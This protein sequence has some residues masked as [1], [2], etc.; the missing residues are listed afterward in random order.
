[1]KKIR[2]VKI[3]LDEDIV[4][5]INSLKQSI[6]ETYSSVLRRILKI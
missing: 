2:K 6:G 3:E 1:M 4:L 5:K